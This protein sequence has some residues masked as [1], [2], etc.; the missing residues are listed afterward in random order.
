MKLKRII[1]ISNKIYSCT[2]DEYKLIKEKEIEHNLQEVDVDPTPFHF[3]IEQRK[4]K[5]KY[6]GDIDFDFNY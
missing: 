4:H 1:L 3:W 5:Y 6:I 2:E